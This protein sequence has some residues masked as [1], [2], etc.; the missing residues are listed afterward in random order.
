MPYW[1]YHPVDT[2]DLE[3]IHI[4]KD[5]HNSMGLN[6]ELSLLQHLQEGPVAVSVAAKNWEFYGG[7]II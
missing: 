6:R 1:P 3:M 7:G 4:A 5:F 2:C